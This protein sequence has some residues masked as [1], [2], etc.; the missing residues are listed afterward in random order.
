M[1]SGRGYKQ[2]R[3]GEAYRE[4]AAMQLDVSNVA[5]AWRKWEMQFKMYFDAT[6]V[7]KKSKKTQA[8]IL[9]TGAGHFPNVRIWGR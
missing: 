1:V 8:V 7:V 4:P 9:L 5:K 2:P 3:N 6:E